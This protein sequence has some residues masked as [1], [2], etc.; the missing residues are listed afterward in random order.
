M[1]CN[2][3]IPRPFHYIY[4]Q[5]D[6]S[7]RQIDFVT[8]VHLRLFFLLKI[9]LMFNPYNLLYIIL[10]TTFPFCFSYTLSNTIIEQFNGVS[11]TLSPQRFIVQFQA[12]T[13]D[14]AAVIDEQ[15]AFEDFLQKSK[16]NYT[17]RYQ[18]RNV[19][20][21]ISIEVHPK[22]IYLEAESASDFKPSIFLEESVK[23][24]PFVERYWPGRRYARPR[25]FRNKSSNLK[26]GGQPNL[27]A[28]HDMTGVSFAKSLNLT[29]KGVK[30]GIIDT[31]VD[32]THPALGGCFGVSE[33]R[34]LRSGKKELTKSTPGQLLDQIR[35]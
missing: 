7:Q 11:S 9:D 26:I 16:V 35:V 20:N 6:G 34:T 15:N 25:T 4:K 1:E 5:T 30:I 31:G 14:E 22:N 29:G 13:A 2:I 32:Y 23:S 3:V 28:A 33:R 10:I 8:I 24:L 27:Q 12:N 17:I 19:M 18:Y 21:A